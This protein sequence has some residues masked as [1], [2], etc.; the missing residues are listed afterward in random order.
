MSA[1]QVPPDLRLPLLLK[2]GMDP[3]KDL[4]N[5]KLIF[6]VLPWPSADCTWVQ[7]DA[8]ADVHSAEGLSQQA[9][10]KCWVGRL[11]QHR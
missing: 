10:M 8:A 3:E 7:P 2:G 4:Q 11:P 9:S 1:V 6:Q 5:I